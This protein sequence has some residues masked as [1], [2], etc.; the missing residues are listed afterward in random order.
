MANYWAIT[1]GINQYQLFQP[2]RC[3]QADAEVLNNFLVQEGGLAQ[4]RCL[5]M[6]A[7]SPPIGDRPTYPTK[8][9]ILVLL[10]DLT[11]ACWQPQDHLWLF[12]SGYGVS[13]NGKDYLM[14]IEGN[15]ELV[16]ET[17]IEVRSLMQSLQLA[18][19]N[20]LLLLD[21]NRAFSIQADS[22]VG[23]E[24]IELAKELQ[25]ATILSCQSQEFSHESSELGH[26]FFTAAL[27]E[28][29]RSGNASSLTDLDSYLSV[30]T[31]ELC[32]HYWRPTQNP[33]TIFPSQPQAILPK[34]EVQSHNE[35]AP[36]T[37]KPGGNSSL[38]FPDETFAVALTAS[39]IGA[40][41]L[42]NLAKTQNVSTWGT[43]PAM[44][45]TLGG[46][47]PSLNLPNFIPAIGKLEEQ[48]LS[49]PA[50]EQFLE[51]QSSL[52]T[53]AA[54]G[55]RF[56]PNVSPSDVSRLPK[57]KTDIP[58][59]KQFLVWGGGT[60]LVVALISVIV[61]RNQSLFLQGK[62]ISRPSPVTA[63]P[64]L[65]ADST[66]ETSSITPP[67]QNPSNAQIAA[68]F[69]SEKRNQAVLDLAKMSLRE[70]QASDLSQAIATASKI[71][72]GEPLYEQAQNNIQIWSRMILDLA[73]GRA[74]Q[75]EYTNAIAAAQ[76]I[77]PEQTLYA[78][79]Q[80][81]I[82]QWQLES[83]QYVGNQT[84]LDAAQA[85]I[86]PGQASTYNRAIEVA[87]RV[88]P[89]QPGFDSAQKSINEWSEK[90]LNLA[91]SR[92]DQGNI[93]AA[94]E[95]ATL[96]PEVTAVYEDAQ[97]AIQKWQARKITN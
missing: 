57:N 38:I 97:A 41:N 21:I 76:L 51:Q 54:T 11:A 89:G 15:P 23:L 42:N 50:K 63:T 58:L 60:M 52:N 72:P 83:Q 69:E 25:M 95:T 9:N 96:V 44:E 29:L 84:V 90:I 64:E 32:Q 6:T 26:G 87:R 5:L 13:Y 45:T 43:A 40:I 65:Q 79:A 37:I 8:Q 4:E 56:I 20:T 55:G 80:A 53:P 34:F 36:S 61:L 81:L 28:A 7:A 31:P 62:S 12:F 30:L 74:K 49:S 39:S 86:R 93:T 19:I 92:A 18:E 1:I 70:T 47:S 27:L 33:V 94:I 24:I 66:S 2:L 14:P 91:K 85:L 59:W 67:T 71:Q 78:Q 10:E 22:P 35:V 3:A 75:Q 17:G 77:S 48:Q 82:N 46:Q 16:E 88:P 68:N 73:E